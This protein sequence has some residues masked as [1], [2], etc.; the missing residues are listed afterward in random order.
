[1]K[2]IKWNEMKNRSLVGKTV[3]LSEFGLVST[4]YQLN[5]KT[6]MSNSKNGFSAQFWWTMA[7]SYAS[8]KLPFQNLFLTIFFSTLSSICWYNSATHFANFTTKNR[9]SILTSWC[10]TPQPSCAT[11]SLAYHVLYLS[12]YLAKTLRTFINA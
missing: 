9:T 7:W 12:I 11:T 2:L 10:T 4:M 5:Y 1:M 8:L 3:C 6:S